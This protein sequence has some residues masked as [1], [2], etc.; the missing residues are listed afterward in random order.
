MATEVKLIRDAYQLKQDCDGCAL[1]LTYVLKIRDAYQLKQD[2]DIWI[3]K[4]V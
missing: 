4:C 1:S 2:C 3:E